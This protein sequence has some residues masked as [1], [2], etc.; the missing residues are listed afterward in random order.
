LQQY[1]C[2]IESN[3]TARAA[4]TPKVCQPST[5]GHSEEVHQRIDY[6]HEIIAS[7]I[8][9]LSFNSDYK[10]YGFYALESKARQWR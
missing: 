3:N 7:L 9:R 2:F 1:S 6:F 4:T 8:V 5:N 10:Q